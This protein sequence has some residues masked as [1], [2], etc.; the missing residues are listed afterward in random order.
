MSKTTKGS[1][2]NHLKREVLVM[3]NKIAMTYSN[4]DFTNN[5]NNNKEQKLL[6][7]ANNKKDNFNSK[8]F[9]PKNA[10]NYKINYYIKDQ[11]YI[12]LKLLYVII[13]N[14]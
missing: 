7:I 11:D 5:I 4:Q 14:Q 9:Y 13:F 12:L 8:I 1:I 6:N 2:I 10:Y 3:A